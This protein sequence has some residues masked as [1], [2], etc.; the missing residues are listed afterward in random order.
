MLPEQ[1]KSVNRKKELK[2]NITFA[3]DKRKK[4]K[5]Y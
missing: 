3:N 4:H 2:K 1:K 5:Y